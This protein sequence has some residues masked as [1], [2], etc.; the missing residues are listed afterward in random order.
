MQG[1][2][3]DEAELG[4]EIPN[5]KHII[6]IRGD[7]YIDR[8]SAYFDPPSACNPPLPSSYYSFE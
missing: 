4:D 7:Y 1:H 8:P 3:R 2:L 5:V 6:M